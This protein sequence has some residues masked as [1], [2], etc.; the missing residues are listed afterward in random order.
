MIMI[1]VNVPTDFTVLNT[2]L[3]QHF[4]SKD[5]I[6]LPLRDLPMQSEISFA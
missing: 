6:E 4:S 3:T 1:Y 5:Q 2:Y